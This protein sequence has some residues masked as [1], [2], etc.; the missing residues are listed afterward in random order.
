M[1]TTSIAIGIAHMFVGLIII[2]ICVP[3]LKGKIGMNESY[4]IRFKKSY[5]SEENWY[6][7]NRYG[8]RQL[9]I[10]SVILFVFG[11]VT[12]F[13]PFEGKSWLV[14][15]VSIAPLII[16]IPVIKSYQFSKRL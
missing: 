16:V 3:L 14:L 9:I 15:T 1:D 10:W 8:A 5:E 4:G 2:L 11:A 6:K 13:I 7:I 12:L